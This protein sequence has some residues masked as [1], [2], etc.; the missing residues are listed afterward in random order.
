[1][2]R[3]LTPHLFQ[4]SQTEGEASRPGA[5]EAWL[6]VLCC[7]LPPQPQATAHPQDNPSLTWRRDGLPLGLS[8]CQHAT[9]VGG[10]G[11]SLRLC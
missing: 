7:S 3:H 4:V 10:L 9:L 11:M 6:K 2:A 1:M 5:W 8:T